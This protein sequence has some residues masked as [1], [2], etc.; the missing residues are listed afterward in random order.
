MGRLFSTFDSDKIRTHDKLYEQ[1]KKFFVAFEGVKAEPRYFNLIE[2]YIKSNKEMSVIIYPVNREKSDGLSHPINVRDGI[3]EYYEESLKE[4]LKEIDEL[5]I[6][7]DIDEH[8]ENESEYLE[9]LET[10]KIN[11]KLKIQAG[12]SNPCFEYW[13]LLHIM[14]HDEIISSINL[15]KRGNKEIKSLKGQKFPGHLY[16]NLHE[17]ISKIDIAIENTKAEKCN[18]VN[19]ELY[20]KI[21]TSIVNLFEKLFK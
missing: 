17:F 5:W 12:V 11:K 8:F 1:K 6:V 10:L 4:R 13:E 3:L 21:G 16:K 14:K 2:Q 20:E 7:I 15:N 18:N 9:F 19:E